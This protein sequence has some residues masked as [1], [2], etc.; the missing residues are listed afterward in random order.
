MATT[1]ARLSRVP[2]RTRIEGLVV[3][4]ENARANPPGVARAV[5][6]MGDDIAA[7]DKQ[8]AVERDADRSPGAVRALDRRRRP[9]LDGPDP[10]DLARRHDDD[11]VAGSQMSGFDAARDDAAVG[12]FVERLHREPPRKP[13]PRGR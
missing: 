4:P 9:A 11:L 6:D 3:Q 5:S 2:S 13:T 7:L 1:V 8:F 12:E 10:G